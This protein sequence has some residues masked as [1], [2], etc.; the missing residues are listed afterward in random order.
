MWPARYLT[1]A[2]FVAGWSKDPSTKVGSVIFREDGSI[3]SLGYNGFARGVFDAPEMLAE[4]E[5]RLKLTIHAEENAILSAGRNGTPLHGAK[6]VVTH[7]PCARCASKIVQA[8]ITEVWWRRD[9]GHFSER[10]KDDLTLAQSVL[11]GAGVKMFELEEVHERHCV[12][13]DHAG[14]GS[15]SDEREPDPNDDQDIQAR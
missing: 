7:H 13:R 4:R 12:G 9:T 11:E 10:W 3:I 15:P 6:I 1:L 5:L 8:G 2:E 14:S